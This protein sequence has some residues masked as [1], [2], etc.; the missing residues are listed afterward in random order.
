MSSESVITEV[1]SEDEEV[2]EEQ[3]DEILATEIEEIPEN[4]PNLQESGKGE[5]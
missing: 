2:V 1:D 5:I 4:T 3:N